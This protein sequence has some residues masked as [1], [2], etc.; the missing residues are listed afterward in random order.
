MENAR[1]VRAA[2]AEVASAALV[3][4]EKMVIVERTDAAEALL[5]TSIPIGASAIA[6]LCSDGPDRPVAEA[7]AQGR[8][9]STTIPRKDQGDSAPIAVRAVPL[10]EGDARVG[11]LLLL[12][13]DELNASSPEAS[14]ELE[15]ILTR[16]R[17]MKKLLAD[18]RKVAR[19]NAS[20]LVRGETG[21]GKELIARAVHSLS[22]RAHGPFRALNCAALPPALLESELFGHVRGAFTGAVRDHKGHVQ[23]AHG[24]T[25]FL[26]EVAELPLELQAKL[27]RV[28][29]E[30][31][32]LP[33]GGRDPIAVDVRFVA[34]THRSLRKE[35]EL[36][37]FRADLMFRLRVVP[38]FLPPLRERRG[39]ILLL[40]LRFIEAK[41]ALGERHIARITP[42]AKRALEEYDWP[43]NVREL[44]NAV[45]YAFVMGEGPMLTEADLPPEVR[46]EVLVEKDAEDVPASTGRRDPEER[47]EAER[48]LAALEKAGG[49]RQKAAH[50][51]GISRVTLWR[52]LRALGIEEGHEDGG[53]S[54]M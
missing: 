51:L 43:G 37:R 44:Q 42:S 22:K 39:D 34:A 53:A 20:V 41:N 12:E 35:V 8:P 5:G 17:A 2:L 52:K 21:S 6:I 15:G 33:V 45:E 16:D 11:F 36:G 29:Q 54:S 25:L 40:A 32:V 46:G 48:I 7:L 13:A 23:L 26:D 28:L 50:A 30:K 24:G 18:V 47:A 38:L 1:V 4:D 9:I 49:S 14:V 10:R 19:S 31:T 3:L 27:L